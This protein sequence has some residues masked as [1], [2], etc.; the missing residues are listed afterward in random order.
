MFLKLRE[1]IESKCYKTKRDQHARVINKG[2]V[3]S[4]QTKQGPTVL[5]PLT[6]GKVSVINPC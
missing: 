5:S 3:C 6:L 1:V 4:F 2:G